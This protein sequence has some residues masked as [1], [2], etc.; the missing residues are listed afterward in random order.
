MGITVG[1]GL[2]V[3]EWLSL[4]DPGQEAPRFITLE[5]RW[6]RVDG[7]MLEA[8]IAH[9]GDPYLPTV[10]WDNPVRSEKRPYQP[11]WHDDEIGVASCLL[12]LVKAVREG[13]NPSYG[14][15]QG[16]LD[17][18]IILAIRQ[19]AREGGAPVMLPLD[20]AAQDL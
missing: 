11:Q 15:L 20:P 1:R 13:S 8:M 14:P 16:R 5:R 2:E 12:S 18:E 3:Q 10:R 6:D 7:G 9:T 19:S 17:Q 4:L